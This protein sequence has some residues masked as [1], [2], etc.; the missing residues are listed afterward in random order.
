MD[1]CRF[2]LSLSRGL[3]YYTGLIYESVL[4]D[5]GKRVLFV[6]EGDMII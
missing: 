2:D 6:E 5:S 1:Y 4:T 3:D